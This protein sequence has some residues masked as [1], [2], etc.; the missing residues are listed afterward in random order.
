MSKKGGFYLNGDLLP[1]RTG[2]E[3]IAI[4]ILDYLFAWCCY[5]VYST[6]DAK[7]IFYPDFLGTLDYINSAKVIMELKQIYINTLYR[8][9]L[10]S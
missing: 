7:N 10:N 5:D 4:N 9:G 3:D 6:T 1:N 8:V 2:H